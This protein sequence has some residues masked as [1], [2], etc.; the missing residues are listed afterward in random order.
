MSKLNVTVHPT[1]GENT[2]IVNGYEVRIIYDEE[3]NA[4]LYRV[5]YNNEYVESFSSIQQAFGYIN[6][7]KIT[8]IH[9][10]HCKGVFNIDKDGYQMNDIYEMVFCSL[11]CSYQYNLDRRDELLNHGYS[12]AE[13]KDLA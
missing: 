13:L 1:D 8:L 6:D 11:E 9:C 4:L 7:M 2:L 10:P 3:L 5:Y 12:E